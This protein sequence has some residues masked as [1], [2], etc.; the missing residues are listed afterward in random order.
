M[1]FNVNKEVRKVF[2]I[3]ASSAGL[4]RLVWGALFVLLVWVSP[5]L[6][7]AIRWW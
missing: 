5:P 1:D 6:V 7:E 4:R 2:E 3:L